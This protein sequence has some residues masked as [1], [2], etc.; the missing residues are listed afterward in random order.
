MSIC[1]TSGFST[2]GPKWTFWRPGCWCSVSAV[3]FRME[4]LGEDGSPMAVPATTGMMAISV[5]VMLSSC[6]SLG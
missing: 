3:S 6:C 5:V 4:A 1:S 2:C